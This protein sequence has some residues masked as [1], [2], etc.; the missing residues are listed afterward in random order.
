MLSDLHGKLLGK[1]VNKQATVN[2]FTEPCSFP[3]FTP[4][5]PSKF[6][7]VLLPL[8][9]LYVSISVAASSVAVGMTMVLMATGPKKKKNT[10]ARV[11]YPSCQ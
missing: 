10:A 3:V 4:L 9:I 5:Q 1:R 11:V 7:C 2:L 8:F 6:Q